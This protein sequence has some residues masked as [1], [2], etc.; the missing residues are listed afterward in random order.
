MALEDGS[1]AF[2]KSTVK[3]APAGCFSVA[4]PTGFNATDNFAFG[5]AQ[6]NN[7]GDEIPKSIV[8]YR[9]HL[10]HKLHTN[11]EGY[12]SRPIRT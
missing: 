8:S 10:G 12:G 5:L 11:Y 6:A 9:C 1:V 7:T 4:Q 3:T 2:D